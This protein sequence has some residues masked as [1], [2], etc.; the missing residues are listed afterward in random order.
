MSSEAPVNKGSCVKARQRADPHLEAAGREEHWAGGGRVGI[1]TTQLDNRNESGVQQP[2]I[3]L[4][5]HAN[6]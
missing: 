5:E 1:A 4:H 3:I 6:I 2:F